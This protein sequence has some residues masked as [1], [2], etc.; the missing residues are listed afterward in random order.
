MAA[1]TSPPRIKPIII[2]AFVAVSVLIGLKFVFDS[3]YIEMFE[4]EEYI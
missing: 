1:D 2:T 4:A 3:Y